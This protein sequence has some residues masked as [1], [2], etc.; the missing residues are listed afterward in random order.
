V[1]S[2]ELTFTE[3]GQE[4]VYKAGE[5]YF[6]TGN[7]AHTNTNLPLRVLVLEILPKDWPPPR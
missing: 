3:G 7:L 4:T 6:E 1:I 2:G 5:Y